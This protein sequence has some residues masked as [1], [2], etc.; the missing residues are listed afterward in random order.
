MFNNSF[1]RLWSQ[2]EDKRKKQ[3]GLLICLM[4]VGSIAELVSIGAI[5]PFIGALT[6]PQKIYNINILKKA[7]N[8][9]DIYN[10]KQII[11]PLTVFF[12]IVVFVSGIIRLLLV[13]VQSRLSYA[14][15]RDLSLNMYRRTLYQPYMTHISRNSS[16]VISGI[17]NKVNTLIN[18]TLVPILTIISSLMVMVMILGGLII[19]DPIVSIS[20][21]IIFGFIYASIIL[22]SKTRMQTYSQ[23]QSIQQDNVIKLLQEG[24]GGIRDVLIDGAQETYSNVYAKS[25]SILRRVQSNIQIISLS[26]RY[27]IESVGL[28]LIALLSLFLFQTR[29]GASD[30][31]PIL[32]ALALGSQRLL[33][34]LQQIY[35]SIISLKS[36]QSSLIDTLNL[37]EQS[38]P[39]K[40][41]SEVALDF[42]KKIQLK[43]IKFSYSENSQLILNDLNLTILKGDRIGIV[44]S[45]GSGKSTILDLLMGLLKPNKGFFLIDDKAI[46][47]SNISSWQKHIAHVPQSIFLSD[48]TVSQNI[49]FGIPETEIDL[50][51]VKEAAQKAQI[52]EIVESWSDKYDTIIGERGVK[53]S[54]GQRQRL[55]IARALYK[56]A[57]LIIFD[58][59]TSALDNDTEKEVMQAIYDLDST[60]TIIIVAHRITTLKKCNKIIVLDNGQISKIGTYS[61]I[62]KI[63]D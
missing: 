21:F 4:F 7:F 9:L 27:L 1:R 52:S 47:E 18:A 50:V 44:G 35:S 60:L 25:D 40:S 55:G 58:E 11:I 51:K 42:K 63:T 20:V 2:I 56:S 62:F 23:V 43:S 46:N 45:T 12:C 49:A 26:P 3:L 8:I 5:I 54:G 32:A 15:G 39:E 36:N 34:I 10:E 37:L 38:I 31:F 53:L 48:S 28:M 13:W 24:L 22:I 29:N 14:I 16:V 57:E 61:E 19:Y 30:V 33:P 41:K 17:A 6:S 59:A